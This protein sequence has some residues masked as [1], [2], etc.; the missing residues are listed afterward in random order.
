MQ[1]KPGPASITAPNHLQPTSSRGPDR[2]A[3]AN[4]ARLHSC[5]PQLTPMA[6][7]NKA[8]WDGGMLRT[9]DY[10]IASFPASRFFVVFWFFNVLSILKLGHHT[11]NLIAPGVPPMKLALGEASICNGLQ[12]RQSHHPLSL[13]TRRLCEPARSRTISLLYTTPEL[14]PRYAASYLASTLFI[15]ATPD[16]SRQKTLQ[17][18]ETLP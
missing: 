7:R 8:G 13:V 16:L 12:S 4:S 5:H 18:R 11:T 3:L 2:A 15:V 17:D 14:S 9:W 6:Y 10:S 1:H